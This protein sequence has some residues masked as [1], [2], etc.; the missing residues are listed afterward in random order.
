MANS[1]V[2]N[3]SFQKPQYIAVNMLLF[4]WKNPRLVDKKLSDDKDQHEICRILWKD[5]A[6]SEIAISIS[7]NGFFSHEPLYAEPH[8][9][10][11]VVIEGN[12]RLAAVKAIIDSSMRTSA[13]I[14]DVPRTSKR[15]RDSLKEIP[16]I[17]CNRKNVWQF[18][19]FKHV[20]GPQSWDSYSKAEYIARIHNDYDIPLNAIAR[21]IGDQHAIVSRLY[22]GLMILEQAEQ[23]GVFDRS[24]RYYR[25]FYFSHLYTGLDKPGIRTYIGLSKDRVDQRHPVPDNKIKELGRLFIWLYGNKEEDSP[26]LIRS[27]NPDLKYLDEVLQS[28]DGISAL[29]SGLPLDVSL[30][31][32]K[33][34]ESLF[35]EALVLSKENLEKAKSKIST[36]YNG[37]TDLLSK[38][39]SITAISESI[40]NEMNKIAAQHI[41][42]RR[43][44]SNRK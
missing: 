23:A 17:V 14:S 8:N 39:E 35:R 9:D 28:D 38:A 22:Q 42:K 11:Y 32:S 29:H 34:D 2:F 13:S 15:L 44:R 30:Q 12:R 36:G 18:I 43:I 27:Q 26:P 4:D 24:S 7:E 37:E 25:R 10:K 19:G 33:G 40:F 3:N 6:S 16:V 20:S 41:S 1:S 5:M 31:I 21:Q